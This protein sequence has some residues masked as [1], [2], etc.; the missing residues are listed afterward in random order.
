VDIEVFD[1]LGRTARGLARGAYFAPG[2]HSVAW[3]G[4]RD[5]GGQ[6]GAGVY[7]VRVRTEGGH[8]TRPVVLTR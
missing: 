5:D 4:R 1:V 8:W 7:F 2:R 3:D 6:A